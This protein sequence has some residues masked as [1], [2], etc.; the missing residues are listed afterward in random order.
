MKYILITL[1]LFPLTMCSENEL[2]SEPDKENDKVKRSF[3]KVIIGENLVDDWTTGGDERLRLETPIT[4]EKLI[5]EL[6]IEPSKLG[7]FYGARSNALFGLVLENGVNKEI[8]CQIGKDTGF[9]PYK[10][11]LIHLENG[12]KLSIGELS[13]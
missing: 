1:L 2:T 10:N 12:N 4:L 8:L 7:D 5:E 3:V 6:R 11:R 13:K 9:R